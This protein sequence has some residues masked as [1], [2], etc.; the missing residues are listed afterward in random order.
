M[1]DV[2]GI[3]TV[4]LRGDRVCAPLICHAK[5]TTASNNLLVNAPRSAQ[6]FRR[7][8]RGYDRDHLDHL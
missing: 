7:Y 2:T 5:N 6:F 8:M 4:S 3:A 1:G